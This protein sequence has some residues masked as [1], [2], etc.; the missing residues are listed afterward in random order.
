MRIMPSGTV[1]ERSSE[2]SEVFR[3]ATSS[4]VVENAF[5][6]IREAADRDP[7]TGLANR[8]YLDRMLSRYLEQVEESTIPLTVIMSDLDQFKQINDN[9]GHAVGDQALVQFATILQSQCR[10]QDLVGA[11][12]AKSSSCSCPDILW[13]Q[14][15]PSPSGSGSSP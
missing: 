6:Q 4:V 13:K 10:Q 7:L 14:P 8:R 12:G 15:R 2:V 3:D 11:L 1:R 9:W 5:R